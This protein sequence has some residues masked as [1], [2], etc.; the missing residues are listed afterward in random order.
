MKRFPVF[1]AGTGGRLFRYVTLFAVAKH[2]SGRAAL[3]ALCFF[4]IALAGMRQMDA[5]YR[6]SIVK[7]GRYSLAGNSARPWRA[8]DLRVGWTKNGAYVGVADYAVLEALA[9]GGYAL[10]VLAILTPVAW[11]AL[12]ALAHKG[13]GIEASGAEEVTA[14]R[15]KTQKLLMEPAE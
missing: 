7:E 9:A 5:S 12:Q 14:P 10:S 8:S 6:Q 11:F 15:A 4:V 1:L 13:G 3:T 2:F